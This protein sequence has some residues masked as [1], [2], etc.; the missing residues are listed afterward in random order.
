MEEVN[1]SS[2][3]DNWLIECSCNDEVSNDEETTSYLNRSSNDRDED[4]GAI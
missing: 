3:G 1:D 4:P 2:G